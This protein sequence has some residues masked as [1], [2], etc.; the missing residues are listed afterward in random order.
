MSGTWNHQRSY[1]TRVKSDAAFLERYWRL[2]IIIAEIRRY[3]DSE[4]KSPVT[5][6]CCLSKRC[7][8][9]HL[10]RFLALCAHCGLR[11]FLHSSEPVQL[12]RPQSQ[13]LYSSCE[14]RLWFYQ[15]NAQYTAA[16]IGL[17]SGM[18]MRGSQIQFITDEMF[19]YCSR[20]SDTEFQ[21]L[22]YLVPKFSNFLHCLG[23]VRSPATCL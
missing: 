6:I 16:A 20:K 12:S 11:T 7:G 9:V 18:V 17:S 14:R 3:D 13:G 10:Q 22:F 23:F 4:V 2:R 21:D 19:L 1:G 5:R 15:A 8:R